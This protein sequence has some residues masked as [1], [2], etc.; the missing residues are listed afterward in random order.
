MIYF[1]EIRLAIRMSKLV[2]VLLYDS[3]SLIR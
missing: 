3:F 1:D 2:I